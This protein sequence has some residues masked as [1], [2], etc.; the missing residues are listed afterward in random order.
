MYYCFKT[1]FYAMK[2][3]F[4]LAI[5]NSRLTYRV[6]LI[7]NILISCT[8]FYLF[9]DLGIG[10]EGHYLSFAEGF[11]HGR[12]SHWWFLSEYYP[13]TFRTP[14]YPVFLF[15]LQIISL[16]IYFIKVVQFIL[17]MSSVVMILK[18]ANRYDEGYKLKNIFLFLLLPYVHV[19]VFSPT[20][21]P[22]TLMTFLLTLYIFIDLKEMDTKFKFPLLGFLSGI[23][24][25]VRPV[26]LFFPI[27]I[28]LNDIITKRN[29]FSFKYGIS[30]L[31][32]YFLTILPYGLWNY[33]NHHV[34]SLT[35]IEGAGG[36]FQLGYWSFKMPGYKEER[37]W[38]NFM[39]DEIISF[40]DYRDTS[41]NILA[42]NKEWNYIDSACAQYLTTS[43]SIT[44]ENMNLYSSFFKTY[45]TKYT[46]EREK[47]LREL[48]I[49][50]MKNDLFFTFKVKLFTL[51]RSW[52][53]GI[54]KSDLESK[55]YFIR[56]RA[57]YFSGVSG[58]VFFASIIL[59]P[60]A[61]IKRKLA[62]NNSGT[63]LIL[64]I[65]YGLIHLPFAIQAR[66]TIPLR[67][68]LLF[69]LARV[70][71]VIFFNRRPT[72]NN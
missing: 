13:D 11:K 43:D 63:I 40:T 53:T 59:I 37:Y 69:I 58:L 10:D 15:L 71:Y 9:R 48:T 6:L 36:V 29:N 64:L 39:S 14:G 62:W 19:V 49:D 65:Y 35:P 5:L 55:N 61:F 34:V 8:I 28:V 47:L 1:Y 38:R 67:L 17:Y 46:L 60:F 42:F 21:E 57:I 52:V 30:M 25:L 51:V 31:L 4:L 70:I 16:N 2:Q 32:I 22:E 7:L 12:F 41:K 44:Y 68:V 54:Q 18:I 23:I 72:Q 45:N 66:Y 26:F 24:F 27:I 3:G 20:I 33:K 50:N 56:I